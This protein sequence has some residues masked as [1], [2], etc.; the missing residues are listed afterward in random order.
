[1]KTLYDTTGLVQCE[2]DNKY[3]DPQ[4]LAAH[5]A[6]HDR[7]L[8]RAKDGTITLEINMSPC[9]KCGFDTTTSICDAE[10]MKILRIMCVNKWCHWSKIV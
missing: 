5:V 9:P 6:M 2:F 3:F 1:M 10:T 4:G 7:D 8:L